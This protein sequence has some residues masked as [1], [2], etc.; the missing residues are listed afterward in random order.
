MNKLDSEFERTMFSN[1]WIGNEG[2]ELSDLRFQNVKEYL[3]IEIDFRKAAGYNIM[4]NDG[5]KGKSFIVSFYTSEE[6]GHAFGSATIYTN[7]KYE[8]VGF[9]DYYDF[10]KRPWGERSYK[11]EANNSFGI[12]KKYFKE[13]LNSI[14]SK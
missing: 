12:P 2:I 6:Y 5:S 7:D 14:Q 13:L 3:S 10:D 8:I 9:L 11:S 4:L 1:Y